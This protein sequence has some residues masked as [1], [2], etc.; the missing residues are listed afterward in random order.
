MQ[1]GVGSVRNDSNDTGYSSDLLDSSGLRDLAIDGN[2][3]LETLCRV[4][5]LE[6]KEFAGDGGR[7]A[8]LDFAFSLVVESDSS[9]LDFGGESSSGKSKN[10]ATIEV[11]ILVGRDG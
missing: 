1:D 4:N 6:F 10:S 11:D 5:S 8:G 7:R 3:N 2:L 9:F